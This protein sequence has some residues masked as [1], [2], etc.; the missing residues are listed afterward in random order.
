MKKKIIP[1]VVLS[2]C[3]LSACSHVPTDAARPHSDSTMIASFSGVSKGQGDN[4]HDATAFLVGEFFVS[5][6]EIAKFDG[7]G[8]CTL[9]AK[10]GTSRA[11]YYAMTERT[12]KNAKVSINT[13][14]GDVVYAYQLISSDGGFTLT[15]SNGNQSVF[16]LKIYE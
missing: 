6:G 5:T 16:V 10:D 12:D 9:V 14:E 2:L 13:G 11:G 3:L 1:I 4:A 8:A 7:R 15:D